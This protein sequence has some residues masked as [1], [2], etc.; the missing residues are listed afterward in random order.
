MIVIN[1]FIPDRL[2]VVKSG[3]P[4]YENDFYL[5]LEIGRILR[6]P[7]PSFLQRDTLLL[8]QFYKNKYCFIRNTFKGT[9]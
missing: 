2:P 9:Q 4:T 7:T 3:V 6:H 5:S 1:N 8:I